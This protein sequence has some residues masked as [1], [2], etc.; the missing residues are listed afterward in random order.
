MARGGGALRWVAGSQLPRDRGGFG[1]S[2]WT[3]WGRMAK[4]LVTPPTSAKS[5]AREDVAW[6]DTSDRRGRETDG[7]GEEAPP[8]G[9]RE[10]LLDDLWLHVQLHTPRHQ[11]QGGWVSGRR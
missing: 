8:L 7:R 9:G 5:P 1:M 11:G 3:V 2:D 4:W 6:R 10:V